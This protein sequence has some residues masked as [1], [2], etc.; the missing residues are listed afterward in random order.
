[1]AGLYP[2]N[3]QLSIYGEQVEWPGM[4]KDTGK[5]TNGDFDDPLKK[6][7]FIPADT[8]NLI[9][10]NLSELIKLMKK[11]KVVMWD[12]ITR[13]YNRDLSGEFVLNIVKEYSRNGSIIVFHDSLRAEK[14]LKYALPKAIEFLVAEGYKFDVLTP[15]LIDKRVKFPFFANRKIA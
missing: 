13:D 6:P 5:F 14:N 12:V 9:L 10:D 1:M 15:Q 2:D 8:F 3:E 4:D 7:S 11:Y